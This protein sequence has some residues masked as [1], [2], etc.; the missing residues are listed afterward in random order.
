MHFMTKLNSQSA[1]S[2]GNVNVFQFGDVIAG[3][4]GW[5]FVHKYSLLNINTHQN[6]IILLTELGYLKSRRVSIIMLLNY[7]AD[8]MLLLCLFPPC[9]P[10]GGDRD[11]RRH[12][13][14]D[15]ERYQHGH[16]IVYI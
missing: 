9:L 12:R 1:I 16:G 7:D 2:S 14:P 3:V 13:D 6:R 4:A 11:Q 8:F 10:T 15:G 5:R